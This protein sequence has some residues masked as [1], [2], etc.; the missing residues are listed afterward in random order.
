LNCRWL[1]FVVTSAHPSASRSQITFTRR[2]YHSHG[3]ASVTGSRWRRA[4]TSRSSRA[5]SL[6]CGAASARCPGCGERR[7]ARRAGR[8]LWR[9]GE[10]F[11]PNRKILSR[12]WLQLRGPEPTLEI[13][14]PRR[15]VPISSMRI[16]TTRR[17]AHWDIS[18]G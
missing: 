13:S 17:A 9:I 5:G 10:V 14:P 16:R 3:R 18:S 15:P 6:S 8:P 4:R 12:D 2:R 7:G 1:P 11:S